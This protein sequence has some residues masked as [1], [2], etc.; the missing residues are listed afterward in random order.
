V[1]DSGNA[2][3]PH[4]HLETR[5]GPAGARFSS[6]AH[7]DASASLEEMD[8]YCAWRVSGW[9]VLLDPLQLLAH[10]P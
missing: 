8:N 10:Q 6:L 3:N 2:L 1:G 9:F 5:V 7:Y 4:L